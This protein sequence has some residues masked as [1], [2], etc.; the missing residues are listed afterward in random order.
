M[1]LMLLLVSACAAAG[2]FVLGDSSLDVPI[3]SPAAAPKVLDNG[4]SVV[5]LTYDPARKKVT[6]LFCNGSG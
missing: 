3:V 5:N 2:E 6:S 1:A 4:C